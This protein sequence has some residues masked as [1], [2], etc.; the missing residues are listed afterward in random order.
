M[1]GDDE[2]LTYFEKLRAA[3]VARDSLLCVG[4][5]PDRR[6][7]SDYVRGGSSKRRPVNS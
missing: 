3:S 2:V 7:G 6:S 1:R 4:L 5:D